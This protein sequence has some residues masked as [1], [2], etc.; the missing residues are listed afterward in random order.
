FGFAHAHEADQ[1]VRIGVHVQFAQAAISA[2]DRV[3]VP[4]LHVAQ[5][6]TRRALHGADAEMRAEAPIDAL[7]FLLAVPLR[8]HTADHDDAATVHDHFAQTPEQL[9]D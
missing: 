9:A 1:L 8:R 6:V 3:V 4:A 2:L 5:P 7:E